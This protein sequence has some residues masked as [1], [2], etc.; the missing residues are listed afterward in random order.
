MTHDGVRARVLL[1][2]AAA[3]FRDARSPFAREFLIEHGVTADECM[4]LSESVGM[5]IELV[6]ALPREQRNAAMIAWAT[7]QVRKPVAP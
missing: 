3:A 4:D 5:C 2:H 7:D 1:R 6:L